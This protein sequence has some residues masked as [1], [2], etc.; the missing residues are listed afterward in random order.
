LKDY[1]A[2]LLVKTSGEYQISDHISVEQVSGRITHFGKTQIEIK[3]ANGDNI[4]L[5]YSVLISKI[6]S[7]QQQKEKIYGY[8]FN[9]RLKRTD[10]FYNDI[11][12]LQQY[13][14]SLPWAHPLYLPEIKQID[15]TDTHYQLQITVFAF[16]KKYYQ[17]IENAISNKFSNSK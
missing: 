17:K 4:Y 7:L 3:D 10:N 2:G 16:D 1:L 8:S 12:L 15:K 6:K 11:D 13:I 9:Y 5:P 14:Q